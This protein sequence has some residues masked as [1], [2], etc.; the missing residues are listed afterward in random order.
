MLPQRS[1]AAASTA[2]DRCSAAGIPACPRRR[3]QGI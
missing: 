1:K 2:R 3:R